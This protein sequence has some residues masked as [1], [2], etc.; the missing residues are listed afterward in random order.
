MKFLTGK[1]S[2]MLATVPLRR[3]VKI[4]FLYTLV[5]Q[6]NILPVEFTGVRRWGRGYAYQE[7]L[8]QAGNRLAFHQGSAG[9]RS[10]LDPRAPTPSSFVHY[11]GKH[12]CQEVA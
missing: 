5:P 10:R 4:P 9:A 11:T 2:D 7:H 3:Y 12:F 6:P 8:R 1:R